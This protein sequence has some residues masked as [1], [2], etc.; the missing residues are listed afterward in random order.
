MGNTPKGGPSSGNTLALAALAL[1]H[2][3][4][5]TKSQENYHL[6]QR[7]THARAKAIIIMDAMPVLNS[8]TPHAGVVAIAVDF[9]LFVFRMMSFRTNLELHRTTFLLLLFFFPNIK[10]GLLKK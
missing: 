3:L 9:L 5:R 10:K 1:P 6:W 2:P 8:S 4:L 7:M